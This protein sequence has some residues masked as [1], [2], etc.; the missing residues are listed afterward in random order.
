MVIRGIESP[1]EIND[2]GGDDGLSS[3]KTSTS[4]PDSH[5][6]MLRITEYDMIRQDT[7]DTR[8]E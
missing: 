7:K 3:Q 4:R 5:Q 2:D 1:T 8:G 6:S